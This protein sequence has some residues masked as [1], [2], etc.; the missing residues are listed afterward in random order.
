M[1]WLVKIKNLLTKNGI[2]LV[3]LSIKHKEILVKWRLAE[4][5]MKMNPNFDSIYINS[6]KLKNLKKVNINCLEKQI[7]SNMFNEAI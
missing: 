4:I 1:I 6:K 3:D 5:K 2:V 7:K